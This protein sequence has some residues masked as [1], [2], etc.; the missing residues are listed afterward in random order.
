M[1]AAGHARGQNNFKFNLEIKNKNKSFKIYNDIF[2][3]R[4]LPPLAAAYGE[5][6]LGPERCVIRTTGRAQTS[7]VDR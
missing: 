7:D 2:P 1:K 4:K 6:R 3:S 5:G